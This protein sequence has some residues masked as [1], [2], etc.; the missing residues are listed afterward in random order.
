MGSAVDHVH[1]R[2]REDVGVR[3]TDVSVER[4]LKLVGRRLGHGQRYRQN[5]IG[6]QPTLV[7]RSIGLEHRPVDRALIEGV[8]AL[9]DDGDLPVDVVDSLRHAL[10]EPSF[11]PI[12]E[13]GGLVDAG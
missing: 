6:P 11:A 1:H 4:D 7:G 13:L 8:E 10:A 12:A 9:E 3:S 5:G 2:D